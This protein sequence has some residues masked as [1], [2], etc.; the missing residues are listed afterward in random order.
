MRRD[1]FIVIVFPPYSDTLPPEIHFVRKI[2]GDG[3]EIVSGGAIFFNY[4]YEPLQLLTEVH[5]TDLVMNADVSDFEIKWENA[6]TN[7]VVALGNVLWERILEKSPAPWDQ[8]LA[9][10]P[11]KKYRFQFSL[12]FDSSPWATE[13]NVTIT[14]QGS[15]DIVD[16]SS[17]PISLPTEPITF[18]IRRRPCDTMKRLNDTALAGG[19]LIRYSLIG[20][21]FETCAVECRELAECEGF[22]FDKVQNKCFLKWGSLLEFGAKG[23]E[24]LASQPDDDSAYFDCSCTGD[25]FDVHLEVCGDSL[26]VRNEA[27]DDGNTAAGDGS[28]YDYDDYDN[29]V[30]AD[31]SPPATS[32]LG[33][34]ISNHYRAAPHHTSADD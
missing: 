11:S 22:T 24:V 15:S 33:C 1:L 19:D 8:A 26:V 28:H 2:D 31:D 16:Y 27:C 29:R 20:M 7:G 14:L 30:S 34:A 18:I 21:T 25:C 5:F 23:W 6:T 3:D 13:A 17:N 12:T 9:E 4:D 32:H 10:M